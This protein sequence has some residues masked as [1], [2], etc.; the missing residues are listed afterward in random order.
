MKKLSLIFCLFFST[1]IFAKNFEV[2]G[3]WV[4]AVPPMAK[5]SAAYMEI[6]NK[7]NK[8]QKLIAAKSNISEVVEIHTHYMDKGYMAMRKV[9]SILVPKNGK[10]ILKPKS[11]HVMFI[12]LTKKLK[13]GEMIPVTLIFDNGDMLEIKAPVKKLK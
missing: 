1:L 12:K 2:T 11:F 3:P 10:A 13:I 6:H 9:D 4:K 8:D 5:M 7:T